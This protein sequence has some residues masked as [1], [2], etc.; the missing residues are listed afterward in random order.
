MTKPL[1]PEPAAALDPTADGAPE[2]EPLWWLVDWV[3]EVNRDRDAWEPA[4]WWV[5]D[6]TDHGV[7]AGPFHSRRAASEARPC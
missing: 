7:L 2:G 3:W 6:W 1:K 4:G 5:E